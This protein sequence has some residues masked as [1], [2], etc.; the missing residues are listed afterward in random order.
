MRNNKKYR[1]TAWM[2]FVMS[3]V[4]LMGSVLTGCSEKETIYPDGNINVIV[5]AKAG[6]DTDTYARILS[7][8]LE[9]ELGVTLTVTNK[10]SA[11]AGTRWLHSRV[12]PCIFNFNQSGWHNGYW[13]IRSENLFGTSK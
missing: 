3:A 1:K 8:Y 6:G 4:L 5:S 9:K 13:S 7:K 12:F 2:G 11:I 10:D